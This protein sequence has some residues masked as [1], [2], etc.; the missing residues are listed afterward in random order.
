[1]GL[2]PDMPTHLSSGAIPI[3]VSSGLLSRRLRKAKSKK[4]RQSE[5]QCGAE[6]QAKEFIP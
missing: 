5:P 4:A 2:S 1:M 3:L 6:R